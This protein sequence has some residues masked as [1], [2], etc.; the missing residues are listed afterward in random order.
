MKSDIHT[1]IDCSAV[2]LGSGHESPENDSDDPVDEYVR[3]KMQITNLTSHR[4]PGEKTDASVLKR[5]SA[6]LDVIKQ[7]YLFDE[8]D[9]E[10]QYQAERKRQDNLALQS[11]LRG[12]DTGGL[13]SDVVQTRNEKK[14][15][16]PDIQQPK[17]SDTSNIATNL[18][19][20]SA[21]EPSSLFE[22]LDDLPESE[23]N[24]DGVT[25][26]IRDMALPKHWSGRTPK[27]LLSET[28]ANLDRY[29]VITYEILSGSSRAKRAAVYIR[30]ESR[31]NGEWKMED[32]ACYDEIQAEAYIAT[33]ALHAVTFPLTD[34]FQSGSS[35]VPGGQTFFRLL[36]AAFRD[37]WD[38][39]ETTR[40][41]RDDAINRS[42][43]ANLRSIV[44]LKLDSSLKVCLQTLKLV[45]N[46]Q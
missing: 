8:Q 1:T 21:D 31:K 13:P 28:I 5:L 16:P 29:A 7:D 19:D 17:A 11:K 22:I 45:F 34:G 10:I 14:K 33:V 6:R 30:W 3:L 37:L 23:I 18:F 44:E 40:K 2:N 9:A 42:V 36:P 26:R 15:R 24:Q 41:A 46:K 27:T 20:A 43:W 35:A 25:V 38:E 39:L 4:T 32:V 12:L